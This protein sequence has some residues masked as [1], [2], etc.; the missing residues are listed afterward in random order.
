MAFI[1]VSLMT[2]NT[3]AVFDAALRTLLRLQLGPP[4]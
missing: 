1:L 2:T 3:N 4:V